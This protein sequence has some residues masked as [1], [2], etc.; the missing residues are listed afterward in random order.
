MTRD[1][2]I[3]QSCDPFIGCNTFLG[4]DLLEN[5][6]QTAKTSLSEKDRITRFAKLLEDGGIDSL[7]DFQNFETLKVETSKQD[8]L[9]DT[10]VFCSARLN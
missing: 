10:C 7:T 5:K 9:E 3:W 6:F 2:S 4:V 8:I 1:V